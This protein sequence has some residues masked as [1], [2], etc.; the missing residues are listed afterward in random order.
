MKTLT[1]V[2]LIQY[3]LYF[4]SFVVTPFYGFNRTGKDNLVYLPDFKQ[5]TINKHGIF[6]HKNEYYLN[7]SG[8]FDVIWTSS[9]TFSC[10]PVKNAIDSVIDFR[11]TTKT[12][13]LSRIYLQHVARMTVILMI[14]NS[15]V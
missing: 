10:L 11:M 14:Q 2:V 15:Q 1:S 9:Q 8:Y 6:G 12:D 5:F 7:I 3:C 13:N 4:D